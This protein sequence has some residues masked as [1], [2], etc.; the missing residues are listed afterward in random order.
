MCSRRHTGSNNRRTRETAPP[1]PKLSVAACTGTHLLALW[2]PS[3]RHRRIL[4]ALDA[5]PAGEDAA[6]NITDRLRA[7][8]M[9]V[10][11]ARPFEGGDFNE[12]LQI[13]GARDL[14]TAL[15]PAIRAL[16]A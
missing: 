3:E 14:R 4:I 15:V 16:T 2:E 11:L 5:D 13:L 8:G 9:A 10:T 7:C 6:A 1:Y 12:D